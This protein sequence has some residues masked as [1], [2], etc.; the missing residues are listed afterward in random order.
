MGLEEL[1]IQ[2]DEPPGMVAPEK[3]LPRLRMALAQVIYRNNCLR[4]V[5]RVNISIVGVVGDMLCAD[6]QRWL[7]TGIEDIPEENLQPNNHSDAED[8]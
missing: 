8:V 5:A 4:D 7:S 1:E 3:S 6:V 2:H